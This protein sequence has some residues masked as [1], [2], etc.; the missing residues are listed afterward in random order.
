MEIT[1]AIVAAFRGD[2]EGFADTAAWPDPKVKRALQIA[3]HETGSGRWGSYDDLSIKQSGMFYFAAH[4]LTVKKANS[5]AMSMGGAPAS[6]APVQSKSVG[7]ESVTYAI[8]TQGMA[9]G[10]EGLGATSYGQEFIRLRRR[11]GRG[12]S[13]SNAAR[14]CR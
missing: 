2:F 5:A 7:D 8:N 4:Y 14:V 3:D 10:D 9:P 6:I 11:V 1:P 13:S 12:G